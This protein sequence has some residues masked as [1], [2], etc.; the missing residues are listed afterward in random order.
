M[1]SALFA[2]LITR[3]TSSQGMAVWGGSSPDTHS[4]E[5]QAIEP[6]FDPDLETG[7]ELSERNPCCLPQSR[8]SR[9]DIRTRVAIMI[10]ISVTSL[11]SSYLTGTLLCA[12]FT[13]DDDD[14]NSWGMTHILVR[15]SIGMFYWVLVVAWTQGQ[16]WIVDSVLLKYCYCS[17]KC[18]A[19]AHILRHASANT[20]LWIIWQTLHLL[21]AAAFLIFLVVGLGSWAMNVIRPNNPPQITTTVYTALAGFCV[22]LFTTAF[23]CIITLIYLSCKIVKNA[24]DMEN[25]TAPLSYGAISIT[26]KQHVVFNSSSNP[27]DLTDQDCL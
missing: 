7:I 12:I 23:G 4:W 18:H 6:I 25:V 27:Q 5:R 14:G 22:L 26:G 9:W 20:L 13:S 21:V 1:L 2:F 11:V 15:T 24:R 19:K 16:Q 3:A 17:R 8:W 10:F